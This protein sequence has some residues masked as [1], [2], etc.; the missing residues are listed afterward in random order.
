MSWQYRI[1]GYTEEK[2]ENIAIEQI[3]SHIDTNLGHSE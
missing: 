2:Y 1:F 3:H